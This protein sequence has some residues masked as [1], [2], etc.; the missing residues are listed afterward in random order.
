MENVENRREPKKRGIFSKPSFWIAIAA[1]TLTLLLLL[2][3]DWDSFMEGFNRGY[4]SV[5]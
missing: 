3:T 1:I 4:N 2:A 5:E